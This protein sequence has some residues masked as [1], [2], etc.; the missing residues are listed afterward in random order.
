MEGMRESGHRG[1]EVPVPLGFVLS[2]GAKVVQIDVARLRQLHKSSTL[3]A[4]RFRSCPGCADCKAER[5][6]VATF[7]GTVL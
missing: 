6:D 3:R 5:G 1:F 4:L 2:G 7:A